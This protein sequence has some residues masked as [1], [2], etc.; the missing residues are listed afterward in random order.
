MKAQIKAAIAALSQNKTYG[1]DIQFALNHLKAALES[2]L[3]MVTLVDW[4]RLQDGDIE[5]EDLLHAGNVYSTEEAAKGAV[6]AELREM[7][8]DNRDEDFPGVYWYREQ[9]DAALMGSVEGGDL[10]VDYMVREVVVHDHPTPDDALDALERGAEADRLPS[11]I[12]KT[13]WPGTTVVLGRSSMNEPTLRL[14]DAERIIGPLAEGMDPDRRLITAAMFL[15]DWSVKGLGTSVAYLQGPR[16]RPLFESN[17]ISPALHPMPKICPVCRRR[18]TLGTEEPTQDVLLDG[19]TDR[20]TITHVK[21]A[22]SGQRAV[23]FNEEDRRPDTW[24]EEEPAIESEAGAKRPQPEAVYRCILREVAGVKV[25]LPSDYVD[26]IEE[27]WGGEYWDQFK[28]GADLVDVFN[29]V[30]QWAIDLDEPA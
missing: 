5:G 22:P 13:I 19:K 25:Y 3:Y 9:P 15:P 11:I 16:Q 1:A 4:G 30:D 6:E 14:D 27:A 8:D 7:W 29:A 2:N 20:W 10:T 18:M 26:E 28:S 17:P 12:A 23:A 24:G 21:C